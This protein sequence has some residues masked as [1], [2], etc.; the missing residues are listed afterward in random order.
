MKTEITYTKAEEMLTVQ[1]ESCRNRGLTFNETC[2]NLLGFTS[3]LIALDV[4]TKWE[5]SEFFQFIAFRSGLLRAYNIEQR[6]KN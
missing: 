6:S 5:S 3:A 2:E 1:F 4:T